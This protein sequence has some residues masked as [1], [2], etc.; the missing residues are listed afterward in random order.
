MLNTVRQLF[1]TTD[2]DAPIVFW[3]GNLTSSLWKP[4]ETWKRFI[5]INMP[6]LRPRECPLHCTLKYFKNTTH[7]YPEKWQASQ[8]KQVLLCAFYI[9]LGSKG[10]A[11]RVD[12][13]KYL[14]REFEVS[15]CVPHNVE[16]DGRLSPK[17][18]RA[19]DNRG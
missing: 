4:T 12:K 9:N 13:N 2:A 8:Q 16:R 15:N 6:E 5:E 10:A 7:L 14:D 18:P 3:I 1:A 11:M 17:R 19:N